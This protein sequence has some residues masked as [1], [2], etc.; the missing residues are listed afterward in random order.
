MSEELA[1]QTDN[2]MKDLCKGE[3]Q[4]MSVALFP[5]SPRWGVSCVKEHSF[6]LCHVSRAS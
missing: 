6:Q 5:G 4:V 2:H 3:S 1:L